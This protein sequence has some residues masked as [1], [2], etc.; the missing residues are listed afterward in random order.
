MTAIANTALQLIARTPGT[1][2]S[3]LWSPSAGLDRTDIKDPVFTNN[4]GVE[5]LVTLTSPAG[6][7]V[8]DTILVTV[9]IN[10]SNLTPDAFVPKAWSPNADGH[11][12]YLYPITVKISQLKYFRI[13]NRWGQ[14]VFETNVIGKGWDGVYNGKQQTAEVFTWVLEAIGTDGKTIKRSGNSVLLR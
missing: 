10:T 12:D 14:M 7:K 8:V 1:G 4:S 6:C 3:Y 13:F 11:N 5:Y 9:R 2:Y